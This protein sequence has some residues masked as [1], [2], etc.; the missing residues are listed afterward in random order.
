[1]YE[2]S[3]RISRGALGAIL[4]LVLASCS[5]NVTSSLGC[6]SLCTDQSATLRDT[7]L[8]GSVVVDSTVTGFPLLG[9][10]R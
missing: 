3:D 1:V 8:V 2:V 5:E 4:F 7:L 6:P 9:E 10:S